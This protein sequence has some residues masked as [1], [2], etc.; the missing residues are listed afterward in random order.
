M[1]STV[2]GYAL[3]YF[4][5]KNIAIA[6][7]VLSKDLGYS[8]TQLGIL[9]TVLYV[10]Y[11]L[12]KLINGA[13]GDHA[14]PRWFMVVGLTLSA[15]MNL[16]FGW[17]SALWMLVLF[18]GLNGWVQSMGFPP[19]ARLL[20]NWY[21]VSERGFMWG[22]W[23]TSHQIGG[24]GIVVLA[25]YLIQNHGWRSGF[26][27]PAVICLFGALL[28]AERLRDTPVS[29]GLPPIAQYRQDPEVTPDGRVVTETPETMRQIV[30]DRVLRNRTLLLA[31]VLN[32]FVYVVRS[33]VFDWGPKFLVE[34]HKNSLVAAGSI[35]ATFELAG[36]GGAL[37]AG[38]ISDRLSGRRRGP[39]C[40]VFMIL[41]AL[42]TALLYL[43][44]AGNP[45]FHGFS[46]ALLGFL[47]Y[48]PQFLVGVFVTDLASSKAAATAIGV[49]GVFGYAGA[50]LS[51]V[52]TGYFVD[53]YGWAGGFGFWIGAALIGAAVGIPLWRVGVSSGSNPRTEK[54]Q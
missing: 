52:G 11:G 51:G 12:G 25:G 44:P 41:T 45:T 6:L 15:L 31:S 20:A 36:I 1:Y 40:V 3:F 23:N 53:R 16:F 33:G 22:L 38:A 5:R 18:W 7:P 26:W 28:L 47:I 24:A 17:S 8:N 29:M 13:F 14:N 4:C 27:V 42:A 34:R 54:I 50:A 43:I 46:F 49:T 10:T 35:T 9:S 48:G 2:I 21:G 39:V 37:L 30:F 32:L 19:C